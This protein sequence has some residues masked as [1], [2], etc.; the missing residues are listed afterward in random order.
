MAAIPGKPQVIRFGVFEV[1]LSAGEL[2]KAGMRQKLTGQPFQVL[3]ALLERPQEIVTRAELRKRLWPENI[4]VDYDLAMKKAVNRLREVL[5]DSAESPRFVET[6]PR[7]GYRFIAPVTLLL[8]SCPSPGHNRL[9]E[10]T[11]R[12]ADSLIIRRHTGRSFDD[13]HHR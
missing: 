4:F 5:G 8:T 1:N 2:R 12:M 10:Q 7:L 11:N 9:G 13:K 3:E 6:V